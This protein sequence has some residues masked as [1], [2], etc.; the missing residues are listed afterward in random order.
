MAAYVTVGREAY[1]SGRALVNMANRVAGFT[2]VPEPS[3]LGEV[4]VTVASK[5]RA[6]TSL[7]SASS[8]APEFEELTTEGESMNGSRRRTPR[9]RCG[10]A[11][12]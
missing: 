8:V 1:T 2:N 7:V 6:V 5:P 4:Y 12:L 11:P 9:S 3:V 10:R